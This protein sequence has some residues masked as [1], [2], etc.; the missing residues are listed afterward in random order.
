MVA[1]VGSFSGRDQAQVSGGGQNARMRSHM[2]FQEHTVRDHF[3][4]PRAGRSLL[5]ACA[6]CSGTMLK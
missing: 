5:E 2:E 3:Q 6:G 1:S 4:K